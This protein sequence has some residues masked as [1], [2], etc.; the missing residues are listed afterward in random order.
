MTIRRVG[1]ALAAT[2]ISLAAVETYLRLY[3]PQA[4]YA[5]RYCS[6][7][8][9]HVPGVS[10]IHGGETGEFVT[11]VRYN[12]QGLRD[13]EYSVE[14]PPGVRR[15]LVFGDSFAE[16][17]EVELEDLFAKRLE[18]RLGRCF[19]G[20]TIQVINFGVSAYDTAQEW[21]YF[22]TEG[23]RYQP[24]LV[25]LLWTGESGSPF[26]RLSDGRPVFVEPRYRTSQVWR[27]NVKT[28][29]KRQFHTASFLSSRLGSG[30]TLGQFLQEVHRDGEPVPMRS[31]TVAGGRPSLPFPAEW[32][33]QMAIFEDFLQVTRAHG[34]TLVVAAAAAP[35]HR[36]LSDSL[37]LHPLPGLITVDLQQV[38][39]EEE[40]RYHF[41]KDGH[42]NIS[43]H[44]KVA[45][46]L[47]D[48]ILSRDLL[49]L[50][51]PA[52]GR[53]SCDVEPGA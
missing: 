4:T 28:F 6:L 50:A 41:P 21:W 51:P 45:G 53:A 40:G 49:A 31:Y 18:R 46:I 26:A 5:I 12:S 10:F 1:L 11:R 8:W 23:V 25:I 22:K 17:L 20:R 30:R 33:T 14:K 47:F 29:L 19:P 2:V 42:W 32:Q 13:H 16:G 37:R 36:Y 24:D 38:S 7:G 39:N 34:A 52:Q 9:C 15:V 48:L 43:G 3:A 44:E 35:D 27:R